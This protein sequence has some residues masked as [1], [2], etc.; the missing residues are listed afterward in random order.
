MILGKLWILVAISNI[1]LNLLLVP[2]L[3]ILGAAIATLLCYIL[4]FAVTAIASKKTMKLPFNTKE[5]LKIVIASAIMGIVVYMM[6][7]I[8]I[9]NVL[10]SIA[11]G[12]IVYFAIIL[13]LKAVTRKEIAFFKDL[14]H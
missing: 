5:L 7:P 9:I 4:A 10:I 8:G 13:I 11:V 14:I 12:V 3:N 2:Y 1:V 6:H